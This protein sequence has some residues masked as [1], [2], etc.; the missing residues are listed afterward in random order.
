MRSYLIRNSYSAQVEGS[1]FIN[2]RF[3]YTCLG[4]AAWPMLGCDADMKW[5]QRLLP[6]LSLTL[7]SHSGQCGQW[8]AIKLKV[9]G[10]WVLAFKTKGDASPTLHDTYNESGLYLFSRK[11]HRR[12]L[13]GA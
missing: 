13:A 8:W 5:W 10:R 6:L 7:C 3:G 9:C 1:A 11:S 12:L 2:L 4:I